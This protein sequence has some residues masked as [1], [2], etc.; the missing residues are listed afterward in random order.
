MRFD[1]PLTYRGALQILGSE[2]SPW[3]DR[4]G[5]ALG[6]AIVTAPVFGLIGPVAG[7]AAIWGWVD[8]KNEAM[9]LLRK[10]V[11]RFR[12]KRDGTSGLERQQL[13]AAAHTA[14]V[15][16][17]YFEVFRES[18]PDLRMTEDDKERLATESWRHSG[19]PL[20]ETLY[21]A[22]VPAPS[23]ACGF[24]ENRA[25]VRTWCTGLSERIARFLEIAAPAALA[26]FEP[27]L[28][29]EKAV[30]RYHSH[31]LALAADVPEFFYWANFGE[32]AATRTAIGGLRADVVAA[33]DEHTS[34]LARLGRVLDLAATASAHG[35]EL[36]ESVWRANHGVLTDP[37]VAV[38]AQHRDD[39]VTFP[40]VQDIYIEPGYRVAT[41]GPDTRPWDDEWWRTQPGYDDLDMFLAA[42]ATAPQSTSVPMLL[43]GNPG[44][45]KSMLTKVIAARLPSSRYTV[46][47]VPLRRV[48]A[49]AQV[50]QQIQQELD[51]STHMRVPWAKLTEESRDT[52]RVV[53]LDGLDEL[54]QASKI[55]RS[56]Y[57]HDVAEFQRRE[58]QQGRPVLVIVTSRTAVADQVKIP[59]GAPIAFLQ[60]FDESR[61][62][63]WLQKWNAANADGVRAG[64]TRTLT[65]ETAL[66]YPHLVGQPLLLLI[67]A[68]YSADPLSQALEKELSSAAL[69]REIFERFAYRE[70]TKQLSSDDPAL[71]GAI[72]EHLWRLQ[73]AALAM[74]NRGAQSVSDE[75]LG[76]DLKALS[77]GHAGVRAS[78]LGQR[79]IGQFFFVHADRSDAH[80]ER[81][82]Q[83]SY[84]FLHATFGEFFVAEHLLNELD[85]LAGPTLHPDVN[86]DLLHA[87][88]SQQAL[89]KR[90]SVLTFVTELSDLLEVDRRERIVALLDQLRAGARRRPPSARFN[91][92][93][94]MG[95][96]RLREL[97]VY[98]LNLLLLRLAIKSPAVESDTS[99]VSLWQ[100]GL[101]PDVWN[102]VIN[103]IAR[104][105][106]TVT[107]E[108]P[109][110]NSWVY[111]VMAARLRGDAYEE[112][113]L[114]YGKAAMDGFFDSSA[115]KPIEL[116]NSALIAM[117]AGHPDNDFVHEIAEFDV[118]ES[119]ARELRRAKVL[120]N[121]VLAL[122][123]RNEFTGAVGEVLRWC[124]R[125]RNSVDI[126][127]Y[128]LAKLVSK[129]PV[130]L[131]MQPEL[132][133]PAIY[134]A[135]GIA[136]DI[137]L[138][139]LQN[140]RDEEEERL[141]GALHQEVRAL[142]LHRGVA[143]PHD[144]TT[145]VE[146]M[147]AS[148]QRASEIGVAHAAADDPYDF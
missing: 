145:A 119:S 77:R 98:T 118:S 148:Q 89:A 65:P 15:V 101:D 4:L 57:L 13:V 7:I 8:Q 131:I 71:P 69:Y 21:Q 54:L 56:N 147:L 135:D 87:L 55:R 73:V 122:G 18:H 112:R 6:L 40:S 103:S 12:A 93:V 96:D 37:I 76:N 139:G 114:Q 88:I 51:Q 52:I 140:A 70:A 53:L 126:R 123:Y 39:H 128:G 86:D 79:T 68:V 117:V 97:A 74:F 66:R 144:V 102:A 60:E 146:M 142:A 33:L 100:A 121:R 108:L 31:Y 28:T 107:M 20:L 29:A 44:A 115:E 47:R 22:E 32:H 38:E 48:D 36:R 49:D 42:Y 23:A 105:G 80:D 110:R 5:T 27:E 24:E 84:E 99:L 3:I 92:Y 25:A 67:V 10:G 106:D 95:V 34:G 124:V 132:R 137:L 83:A 64:T 58:L 94:P 14:I 2:N 134:A 26:D 1:P 35:T 129:H 91:E 19:Q 130:L 85:R 82:A 120:I 45:G 61:V 72:Q 11:A 127:P 111:N 30:E 75:D 17:S 116:I 90:R 104:N 136:A 62:R 138:C 43:L 81:R 50:H 41:H 143:L 46:V 109:Y 133:D 113:V 16:G 63:S 59:A 141:L 125:N 78:D 9:G